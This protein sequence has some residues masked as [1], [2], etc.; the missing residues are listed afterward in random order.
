MDLRRRGLGVVRRHTGDGD[1]DVGRRGE[2]CVRI[3]KSFSEDRSCANACLRCR[4]RPDRERLVGPMDRE[5]GGGFVS[6]HHVVVL[7]WDH[8]GLRSEWRGLV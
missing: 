1:G 8:A 2:M 3:E 7:L 4:P 6:C 5:C